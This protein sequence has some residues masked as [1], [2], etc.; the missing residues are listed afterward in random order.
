MDLEVSADF[1]CMSRCWFLGWDVGSWMCSGTSWDALR[2]LC[3]DENGLAEVHIANWQGRVNL[4]KKMKFQPKLASLVDL[5]GVQFQAKDKLVIG[6]DAPLGWPVA[7]QELTNSGE[8]LTSGKE[9]PQ[10]GVGDSFISNPLVYRKTEQFLKNELLP[11]RPLSAVADGIGGHASKAQYMLKCMRE[12]RGIF[13]CPPF[14]RPPF[15]IPGNEIPSVT[16]IEVYPSA[17]KA[18]DSYTGKSILWSEGREY[19]NFEQREDSID[20]MHCA[21]TAACYAATVGILDDE[22]IPKVWLP[23]DAEENNLITIQSEGWIYCPKP[24]LACL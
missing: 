15:D 16:I 3:Y 7:F 10:F 19:N 24:S 14:D 5:L 6:V 21:L 4:L 13:Y 8:R 1:R 12:S 22:S 20:A 18:S 17:S 2:L 9:D 11:R 23:E